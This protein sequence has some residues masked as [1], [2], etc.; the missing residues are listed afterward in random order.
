MGVDGLLYCLSKNAGVQPFPS[1]LLITSQHCADDIVLPAESEFNLQAALD[2]VTAWGHKWRFTLG[3]SPTKSAV[4][5][6]G[7]R[8]IVPS[9]SF[10]SAGALLPAVHEYTYLGVV[11]VPLCLLAGAFAPSHLT[12]ESRVRPV[13]R[14]VL[15]GPSPSALCG[16]S[17]LVLRLALH[18]VV[19]RHVL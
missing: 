8:A 2:A 19:G 1:D 11:L 15:L 4:L 5:V 13:C 6:F 12:W 3:I 7:P 17:F 9:C 10:T 14:M 18:V 16:L